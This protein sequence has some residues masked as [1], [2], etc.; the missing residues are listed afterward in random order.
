MNPAEAP[1]AIIVIDRPISKTFY[2]ALKEAYEA[3]AA[4]F[5]NPETGTMLAFVP[6]TSLVGPSGMR[7]RHLRLVDQ[8][9]ERAWWRRLWRSLT[10]WGR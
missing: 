7:V 10:G 9:K 8:A 6:G 5:I 1:E 2:G 4:G 3:G